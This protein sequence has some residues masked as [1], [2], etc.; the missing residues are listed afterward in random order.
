MKLNLFNALIAEGLIDEKQLAECQ[1]AEQ[2]SG[3]PIDRVLREKG[4]ISEES[5]LEF[6][7]RVLRIPFRGE[8]G[9]VEVPKEFVQKVPAQFAR[10]YNLV[11]ISRS[12]GT[13]EVATSDPLD[14][15]PMDDL[16]ALLGATVVPI[17]APRAEITAV[18][19]KAYQRSS[20]NVD[21][22]LDGIE[23]DD[24]IN[25]TKVIDESEDVLDIEIGRAHV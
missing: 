3:K 24:M 11:G 14:I 18:V 19:N 12:N 21:E 20:T 13:Y 17:V 5:L 2:E 10:N 6:L 15:H 25:L 9:G 16:A 4:Y 8:L 23:D 1:V 7:S 22:L